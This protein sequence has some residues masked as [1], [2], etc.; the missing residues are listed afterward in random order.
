[1]SA[2]GQAREGRKGGSQ[3]HPRRGFRLHSAENSPQARSVAAI[4]GGQERLS[5]HV[6]RP[7]GA[8]SKE[9][10]ASGDLQHRHNPSSQAIGDPG[11]GST[12]GRQAGENKSDKLA[13]VVT[14]LDPHHGSP[15]CP[16]GFAE[17]LGRLRLALCRPQEPSQSC[18]RISVR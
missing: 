16:K 1:M 8:R 7:V 14:R 3:S 18:K 12:G 13:G 2:Y 9:S 17:E 4:A 11:R 6:Y 15:D 5:S 10:V